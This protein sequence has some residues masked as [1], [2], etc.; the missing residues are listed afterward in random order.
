MSITINIYGHD[1]L[2]PREIDNDLAA[3]GSFE[4]A[5]RAQLDGLAAAAGVPKT[6]IHRPVLRDGE[7]EYDLEGKVK[8]TPEAV[9]LTLPPE[10]HAKVQLPGEV[11]PTVPPPP[12]GPIASA[13][14]ANDSEE[15]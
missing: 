3:L 15:G 8:T 11:T 12:P 4:A 14:D 6:T 7:Y 10:L 13:A 9:W 2:A 5:I 1:Y